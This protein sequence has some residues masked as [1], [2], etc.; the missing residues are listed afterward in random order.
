MVSCFRFY[1][2]IKVCRLKDK[3]VARVM[4]SILSSYDFC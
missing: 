4:Y 2:N 3:K 1:C